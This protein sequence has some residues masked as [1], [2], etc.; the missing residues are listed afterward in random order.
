MLYLLDVDECKM[1]HMCDYGCQNTIGG[2][3]CTCPPH[4]VLD[5]SGRMCRGQSFKI[6]DWGTLVIQNHHTSLTFY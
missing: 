5:M 2:Y 1:N 6:V 4:K 3:K